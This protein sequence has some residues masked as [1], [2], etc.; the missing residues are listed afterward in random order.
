M[1]R[2]AQAKNLSKLLSDGLLAVVFLSG[3]DIGSINNGGRTAGDRSVFITDNLL[4]FDECHVAI[5]FEW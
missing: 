3:T 5:P 4:C 1:T 2:I